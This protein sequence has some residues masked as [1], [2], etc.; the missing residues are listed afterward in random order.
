MRH[1]LWYILSFSLFQVKIPNVLKLNAHSFLN[2]FFNDFKILNEYSPDH[3]WSIFGVLILDYLKRQLIGCL[4]VNMLMGADPMLMCSYHNII[5]S[6]IIWITTI[7]NYWISS[8]LL[9][10]V[11]SLQTT[12]TRLLTLTL[13]YLLLST[14][15]YGLTYVDLLEHSYSSIC[16]QFQMTLTHLLLNTFRSILYGS[17]FCLLDSWCF[18]LERSSI[19][20]T[21]REWLTNIFWFNMNLS[22]K[23]IVTCSQ[24]KLLLKDILRSVSY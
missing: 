9:V 12:R 14:H 20:L 22:L 13:S 24:S 18:R 6:L 15:I 7:T 21:F 1:K 17:F 4:K 8:I 3:F 19:G 11:F 5:C 16:W 2:Y 10:S 23:T